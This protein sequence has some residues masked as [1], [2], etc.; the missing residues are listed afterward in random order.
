MRRW[1]LRLP[2][3]PREQKPR[4]LLRCNPLRPVSEL[5]QFPSLDA[6]AECDSSKLMSSA[7]APAEVQ[8]EQRCPQRD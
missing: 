6:P 5:L 3:K 8:P 1:P 4:T 7:A 2:R